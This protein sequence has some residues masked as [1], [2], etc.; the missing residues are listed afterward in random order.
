MIFLK[1]T[2]Y[3]FRKH[4]LFRSI[5]VLSC[6]F[7]IFSLFALLFRQR[8]AV[9]VIIDINPSVGIPGDVMTIT[10]EHFGSRAVGSHVDVGGVRLT[11]SSYLLWSDTSI[12]LVL[13]HN[14]TDGLVYVE[15]KNG[16]SEPSIFANKQTIPVPIVQNV[17]TA[18]P[19][20]DVVQPIN[21]SIGSII[22]ID[23]ANFGVMR[24]SSEVLFTMDNEAT[25][26]SPNRRTLIP[27]S[28]FDKDYQF[29]SD[30][31]LHVRV[32]EG[33]GTGQVFVRTSHGLS[34]GYNITISKSVGTKTYSE[35]KNYT[36]DVNADITEIQAE[37][38]ATLV[39][40]MPMPVTNV[41]QRKVEVLS[42]YPT[43]QM[44]YSNNFVHQIS[45]NDGF[46]DK[47]TFEHSL[48]VDVY[49]VSTTVNVN[50]V[51]QYSDS[52]R[53]FYGE[54][55]KPDSITFSDNEAIIE[56]ANQIIG[57]ET[58][59]WRKARLLYDWIIENATIVSILKSADSSVLDALTTSTF[60]AYEVAVLYTALLRASEIPALTNAGILV[61]ADLKTQN[62]WWCEF[63][64][65]GLG[66]VPVDPALGLSLNYKAFQQPENVEEY[67]FG[68]LDAQHIAF[69]RGWNSMSQ[70]Q[71]TGKKVYRPKTYALQAVWEESTDGILG[72]S[73]YWQNAMVIGV[74]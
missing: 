18:N 16:K 55:L 8:E 57:R 25:S 29:W 38:H 43:P 4:P 48:S 7:I 35:M 20:I 59:P 21:T 17:R 27:C 19:I 52:I 9:P 60:D 30:T 32:P 49:S 41:V 74:Y 39:L 2:R 13:P 46:R 58:N 67:Y 5:L 11:S 37:E 47:L 72:Y 66:W 3:Y 44:S 14:I 12:K 51:R 31:Q 36:V 33:A 40:F 50:S 68:N 73:S 53:T 15:T 54:Y 10:G 70:T 65:E 56:L 45:Q 23:G 62:H 22:S 64:I 71:L 28:E 69:S 42:S 63:Y 24:E 26:S 1:K 34:A 6:V 61:D